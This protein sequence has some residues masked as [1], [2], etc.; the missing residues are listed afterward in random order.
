M[1]PSLASNLIY[2]YLKFQSAMII[3]L[4]S[5]AEKKKKKKDSFLKQRIKIIEVQYAAQATIKSSK[6]NLKYDSDR[7]YV[8]MHACILSCKR[9][10]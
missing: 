5:H 6:D 8:S 2:L 9:K 3:S 10:C 7:A 1:E 4:H